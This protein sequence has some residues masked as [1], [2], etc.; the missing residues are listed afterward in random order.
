MRKKNCPEGKGS[1][2]L[3]PFSKAKSEQEESTG[4]AGKVPAR[5]NT[6]AGK[7]AA[8]PR[9]AVAAGRYV[10]PGRRIDGIGGR[11]GRRKKSQKRRKSIKRKTRKTRKRN[12]IRRRKTYKRKMVKKRRKTHKKRR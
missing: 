2:R 11:G 7:E 1:W 3:R 4:A 9:V 6:T 8:G 10:P 12:K 5:L